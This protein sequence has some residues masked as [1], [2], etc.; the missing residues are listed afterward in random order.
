MENIQ[1]NM[2]IL[3]FLFVLSSYIVSESRVRNADV[4]TVATL[5][6]ILFAISCVWLQL[7]FMHIIVYLSIG[8]IISLV[9]SYWV[10]KGVVAFHEESPYYMP[11]WLPFW[12]AQTLLT[13]H[14]SLIHI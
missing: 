9:W 3:V 10:Q 13:V 12:I 2:Y 6:A 1:Q 7:S 4:R 11:Y 8:T 5:T 14:L